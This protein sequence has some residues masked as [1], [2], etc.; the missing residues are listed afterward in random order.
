LKFAR[1]S[2]ERD[3]DLELET[4][5]FTDTVDVRLAAFLEC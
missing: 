2:G 3:F 5:P 1:L 4:D